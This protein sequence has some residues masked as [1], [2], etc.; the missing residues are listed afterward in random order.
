MCCASFWKRGLH[1]SRLQTG[2]GP[3][4]VLGNDKRIRI[5]VQ[6]RLRRVSTPDWDQVGVTIGPHP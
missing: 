2:S 3:L 6:P 5:V 4:D 1:M